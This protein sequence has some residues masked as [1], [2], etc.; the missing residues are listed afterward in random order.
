[1]IL[2]L[3]KEKRISEY[4]DQIKAISSDSNLDIQ[5]KILAENRIRDMINLLETSYNH[6]ILGCSVCKKQDRDLIYIHYGEWNC[7][8]CYEF[9]QN[10]YKRHPEEANLW[11]EQA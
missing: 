6:S 7:E 11:R 5:A 9:I 1:T 2:R 8:D 4:Y 3:E 10:Y